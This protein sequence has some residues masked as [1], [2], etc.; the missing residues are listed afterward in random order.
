MRILVFGGNSLLARAFSDIAREQV[1][2]RVAGHAEIDRP[3]LLDGVDVVVNFARHPDD[4]RLPHD[5]A[6]D[7]D[8]R[9]AVRVAET[10]ARFVMLSS[11]KVYDQAAQWGAAETS[12]LAGLD[13]YGRNK[14]AAEAAVAALIAPERLLVLRIGN[15]IGPERIPGRRSFMGFMLNT[16]AETGEIVFDMSPFVARDF[17]TAGHFARQL[18][19]AITNGLSGIYNLS[20]GVGLMCGELAL[21][22]IRG[23]GRGQLRI[24][25]PRHADAFHLDVSRLVQTTGLRETADDIITYCHNLGRALG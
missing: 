24:I 9:L 4:M 15:V 2:L 14:V 17:V 3:D 23:H 6:R 11:R 22:V 19:A 1:E 16:L 21:A 7:V 20:S 13:I 5:P 10:S 25:D 8:V 12:P 18:L